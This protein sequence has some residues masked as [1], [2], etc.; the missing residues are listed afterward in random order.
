MDFVFVLFIFVSSVGSLAN[1]LCC[2]VFLN[3]FFQ[4][5]SEPSELGSLYEENI[6]I[7]DVFASHGSSTLSRASENTSM[8]S[9]NLLTPFSVSINVTI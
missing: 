3:Y 5:H 2:H 6:D 8:R 4:P 7:D 1:A 9:T